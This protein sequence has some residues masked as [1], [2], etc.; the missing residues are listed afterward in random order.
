MRRADY[1]RGS[2]E[3]FHAS[4]GLISNVDAPVLLMQNPLSLLYS[5]YHARRFACTPEDFPRPLRRRDG[6][7]AV[8]EGHFHQSLL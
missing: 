4:E 1:I 7:L 2:A 3:E 5:Q 6:N 8:F